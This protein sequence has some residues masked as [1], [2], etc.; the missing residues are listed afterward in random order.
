METGLAT[1]VNG[2]AD[3]HCRVVCLRLELLEVDKYEFEKLKFKNLKIIII[4][5]KMLDPLGEAK[6]KRL[7][8]E[9]GPTK[10][11][12]KDKSQKAMKNTSKDVDIG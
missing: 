12:V 7:A 3:D 6:S 4:I 8:V 11:I 1:N 9:E 5:K 10:L 2:E